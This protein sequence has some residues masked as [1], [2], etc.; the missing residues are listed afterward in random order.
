MSKKEFRHKKILRAFV[1]SSAGIGHRQGILI[2]RRKIAST[3]QV[4]KL[5]LSKLVDAVCYLCEKLSVLIV[6]LGHQMDAA[7][8]LLG[9]CQIEVAKFLNL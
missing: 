4:R 5:P 7:C 1:M 2:E 9:D 6:G 3:E 8:A